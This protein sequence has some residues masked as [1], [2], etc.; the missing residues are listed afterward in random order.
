M[1]LKL[2][3]ITILSA[4]VSLSFG[5]INIIIPTR[6]VEEIP[7]ILDSS[8]ISD[9]IA[10]YGNNYLKTSTTLAIY[11]QY[12]QTGLTFQINPYDKNQIVRA[13]FVESP[14]QAKTKN[15]IVL[16][17]STMKDVWKLYNES[18]CFTSGDYA[19][20][21]QNGISFYIKRNPDKKGFNPKEQIFK[22]KIHNDEKF[23]FSSNV[24]FEF[25]KEPIDQKMRELISILEVDNVDFKQLDSFWVTQ[26]RTEKEPYGL[27][28]R[29][30]FERN[31]QNNLVQES[32]ELRI[33]GSVYDLNVIKS[34][35]S[36]AY[37]KLTDIKAKKIMLERAEKPEFQNTN[38]DVFTYGTFCGFAGTPPDKCVEMLM[39]VKEENYKE[40]AEWLQSINPE[41]ATYG[42]IGIYFLNRKGINILPAETIR[43]EELSK[44]N[45][46]LNACEGCDFG[47]PRKI[48][49]VLTKEN[50]EQTFQ[51]FAKSGWLK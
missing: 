21:S 45:I 28:K 34:E 9:V 6:G 36:V 16:N 23:G 15:G 51:A 3:N 13:I 33:A 37:L 5:Q 17:E 11:Y 29:T 42:F 49:E 30:I 43:M 50:L 47:I 27:E 18:G 1:Y 48:N 26:K 44:S 4:W 19:W 12:T 8:N 32:I 22:I 2:L 46:K 35:Y 38:F 31:I 41:I 7:V 14:F 10:L 40:L 20:D 25:N 39:L 24:N